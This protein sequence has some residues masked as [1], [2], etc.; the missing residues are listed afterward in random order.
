MTQPDKILIIAYHFPPDA[1]VGALRPQK[2][3][4]YLPEFGWKPYV[5][6]IREQFIQ[7]QDA[8][9]LGDV[10]HAEII[11]TDYWRSPL[12]FM[13]D[14]RDKVRPGGRIK[15]SG[16]PSD[17]VPAAA[18]APGRSSLPARLK[19][20]LFLF[21]WFPDD[22]LYWSVPAV[23][24]GY[25]AIR[26]EK[27]RTIFVTAPPHT[28]CLVGLILSIL[29]GARLVVDFRD[30]W[31]LFRQSVPE[32]LRCR[33]YDYLE[34]AC[35]KQV[36]R[37]ADAVICT[38][39]RCAAALRASYPDETAEKFV[40][41][42]NGYDAA[43]FPVDAADVR[44]RNVF[45]ISY[46]G[47]FYL[48]RTPETFL[49]ALRRLIDGGVVPLHGIEVRFV[50]NLDTDGRA[51]L[52]RLLEKY[53]MGGCVRVMGPVPYAD[54]L[55]CM[56]ESDLLLLFAPNQPLQVPAKAFEYLGARRPVL[57]FTEE[58]AT[59]DLVRAFDAGLV[60]RQDDCDGVMD[61]LEEMYQARKEG[62]RA[63]YSRG[64]V[65]RLERK[66]LTSRLADI[67][68]RSFD[69]QSQGGI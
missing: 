42:S 22:K 24:A 4:K 10:E 8:S 20:T 57:A 41:I 5:L 37:R 25:R 30:P 14:L 32:F 18:G 54:A 59:A 13:L 38:T 19:R 35:E 29:T 23:V 47:T 46:L 45:V 6:T 63:W 33:L 62:G 49:A 21:N 34:S 61:A 27:I 65:S 39:P 53:G 26:R 11:R 60:V 7:R 58:G 43:D 69:T 15:P 31:S 40:T 44:C 67:L 50:G 68:T 48:D 36:I 56:R 51:A 2:F 12:Q 1:A 28:V 16:V 9:R 52:D 55:R 66:F 3:V 64:D 17:A